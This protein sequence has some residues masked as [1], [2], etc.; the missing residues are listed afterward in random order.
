MR[1]GMICASGVRPR[2]THGPM[3]I[4]TAI[5]QL[6]AVLTA[7]TEVVEA[8]QAIRDGYTDDAYERLEEQHPLVASLISSVCDLEFEL[9][10]ND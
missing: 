6:A 2:H 8:L 10:R 3:S 7:S 1:W 9:E 5:Q 4:A